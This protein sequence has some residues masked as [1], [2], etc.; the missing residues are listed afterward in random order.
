MRGKSIARLFIARLGI[1]VAALVVASFCLAA[2]RKVKKADL[3]ADVQKTAERE[4]EG[5]RVVAYWTDEAE[6]VPIYEVDLKVEGHDKGV[7]IGA[8]GDVIAVQEEVAWDDLAPAVQEGIRSAAG[9]GKIGKA[10]S[11]TQGGDLVGYGADV[12]REGKTVHVEVGPN[13]QPLHNGDGASNGDD[14]GDDA[15]VPFPGIV[16]A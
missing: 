5:A 12:E 2:P 4:S 15:D 3:P 7:L 1:A 6:G 13:G 8:D 10:H 14:D 9:D 16:T 11:V